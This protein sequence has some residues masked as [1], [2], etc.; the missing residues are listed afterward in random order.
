M[1]KKGTEGIK[2]FLGHLGKNDLIPSVPFF[3][4]RLPG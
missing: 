3:G 4:V 1:I 2:S